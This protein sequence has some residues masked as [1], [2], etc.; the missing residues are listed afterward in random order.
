MPER[1]TYVGL[2]RRLP[3]AT[4]IGPAKGV[5]SPINMGDEKTWAHGRFRKDIEAA[6]A[7]ATVSQ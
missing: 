6:D 4:Q 7:A 3:R 1:Q 2:L 5:W